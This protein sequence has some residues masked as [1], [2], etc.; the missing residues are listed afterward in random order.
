MRYLQSQILV[1][2]PRQQD[3]TFT[4]TVILPV[5]YGRKGACGVVLNRPAGNL[6]RAIC[7]R[8]VGQPFDDYPQLSLGGPVSGPLM[9][10]HENRFFGNAELLPELFFTAKDRDMAAL[11]EQRAH[12]CR[13][14]VGYVGWARGQ[15]ERE[16][17]KGVWLTTPATARHVFSDADGLW[18][19]LLKQIGDPLLQSMLNV[20]YI[21][22]NPRLN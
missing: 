18:K 12:P 3:P 13:V 6:V 15:I 11:L 7:E 10:L 19:R 2:S 22:D 14:F 21:P 4:R 20:H 9:A 5:Q 16:L 17:E 1:A 8:V